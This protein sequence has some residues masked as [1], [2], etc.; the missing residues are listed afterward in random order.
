VKTRILLVDDDPIERT[1]IRN[2][3]KAEA[4]WEVI[5]ATDGQA[6]LDLLCDRLDPALCI[7]DLRMPRMDGLE[8]LQRIRRDPELKQLKVVVASAARDRE[9]IVACSRLT[10][11]GYLLKPYDAGKTRALVQ[12]LV[13]AAEKIASPILATRNLL[14]KTVFVADDSATDR[15]ALR[16][17]IK[18]ESGWDIIET[19]DGQDAVDQLR[20]GLRPDLCLFDLKMPNLDGI[21]VLKLMRAD[22]QLRRIPVGVISGDKDPETIRLLADLQISGYLLKPFVPAKVKALLG[23]AASEDVKNAV[24]SDK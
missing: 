10:I 24:V 20:R 15:T 17:I 3:F 11:S 22:P 13:T 7:V 1:V 5:E 6:A 9:T 23:Q 18:G 8:L 4:E 2:L 14:A 16:E 12:Q 21:A 19:G